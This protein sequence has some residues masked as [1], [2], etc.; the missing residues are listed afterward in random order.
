MSSHDEH[1]LTPRQALAHEPKDAAPQVESI[2][3]ENRGGSY[4]DIDNIKLPREKH[5]QY[6]DEN[7]RDIAE[8]IEQLGQLQ[9]IELSP[10]FEVT[11]GVLRVKALEQLGHKKVWGVVRNRSDNERELARIHEN[12]ARKELT[13][14]ERSESLARA[15]ELHEVLYPETRQGAAP[16]RPGGGKSP[17]PPGPGAFVEE[18]SKKQ[19]RGK[20]TISEEVQIG[21]LSQEVRDLLRHTAVANNKGELKQFIGA[22]K[23]TQ[24]KLAEAIH[25]GQADSFEKARQIVVSES[26]PQAVEKAARQKGEGK[27]AKKKAPEVFHAPQGVAGE[28]EKAEEFGGSPQVEDPQEE[29]GALRFSPQN[30]VGDLFEQIFCSFSELE[31]LAEQDHEIGQISKELVSARQSLDSLRIKFL[32]LRGTR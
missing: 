5:R 17:K 14:L 13:V 12:L 15:K 8:S 6:S 3:D 10:E 29:P 26:G 30:T 7:I 19:G 1:H 2:S 18:A 31:R 4:F 11:A 22:E 28:H 32:S 24:V 27:K 9:P 16:G 23:A 21:N 20:S 25:K